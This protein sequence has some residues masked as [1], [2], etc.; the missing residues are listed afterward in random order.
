[1]AEKMKKFEIGD[2]V[3]KKKGRPTKYPGKIVSVNPRWTWDYTTGR[4]RPDL[5]LPKI[6]MVR[7]RN[8]AYSNYFGSDLTLFNLPSLEEL[9]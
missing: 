3:V 7:W 9:M 1:M 8:N 4:S 5:S 2:E 6:Y